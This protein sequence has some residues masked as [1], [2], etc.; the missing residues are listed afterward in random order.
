MMC[1]PG[2]CKIRP[3]IPIR[4]RIAMDESAK[5]ELQ[6]SNIHFML[7]A[8][9][10]RRACTS[11][12]LQR[13]P[14]TARSCFEAF[15]EGAFNFSSPV[16]RRVCVSRPPVMAVTIS[17]EGLLLTATHKRARDPASRRGLAS[18]KVV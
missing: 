3:G 11:H 8:W 7:R 5:P 2:R 13:L 18:Q 6:L 1:M 15:H 10:K 14:G 4:G 16:F 17:I 12:A 9:I